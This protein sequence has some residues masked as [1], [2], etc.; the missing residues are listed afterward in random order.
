[1]TL[2][3][4]GAVVGSDVSGECYR[5]TSGRIAEGGFG[6]IYR[7]SLLDSRRDPVRD[8]AIKALTHPLSWHGEAY[9]G[10]LLE[11]QPRVVK[12]MD[13]FQMVSGSGATRFTR[14]LLVFEWMEGGT[15]WDFLQNGNGPASGTAV[16]H[17]T[18]EIL[19]LLRLLHRRGIC[20]GDITPGNVFLRD[21]EL[22]LGDLGI[23]KQSLH[24][25]PLELDASTPTVFAPPDSD[26]SSWT[27]SDDVYQLALIA[28]SFLAGEVVVSLEVC[29]RLLKSV[30]AGDSL[31]GW[32]RDA[33]A[34][35]GD[36]FVDA[37]EALAA[38]REEPVR[39]ARAPRTL[40]GQHVVFTGKLKTTRSIAQRRAKAAGAVIQGRVSGST[41]L[42][43]AGQPN[44]LQI[45]QSH[46]TKLYDAHRRIRRGQRISIINEARFNRLAAT[47]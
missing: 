44:P 4:K 39:P 42:L 31:K 35:R 24:D 16:A 29:G 19:E 21:G 1:V 32:I 45:G 25:G 8:V 37:S 3:K 33:L 43:V 30:D 13:A 38:L 27:P 47:R 18:G 15:V 6:E 22:V 7:G 12:F 5:V 17:Q 10:R 46:G 41:S 9:F 2:L 11:D 28:L 20:H 14:Y 26:E 34:A 23:A 40:R 36:R